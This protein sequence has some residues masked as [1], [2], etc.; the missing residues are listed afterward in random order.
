MSDVLVTTH[1]AEPAP[2]DPIL[3]RPGK[4]PAR[5][6]RY[7]QRILSYRDLVPVLKSAQMSRVLAVDLET[8]GLDYHVP[9]HVQIVG[10]GLAWDHGSCYIPFTELSAKNRQVLLDFLATFP[11]ELLAHNAYFDMGVLRTYRCAPSTY[12]CTRALMYMLSNEGY[13]GQSWGLKNA[14]VSL[15]GW[16]EKGDVEL[17]RWLVVN[18]Y[19]VGNRRIDTSPEYLMAEFEAK[20]LR[21]DKGQMWHAPIDILGKYCCLDAESTYLLFTEILQ[22]ALTQ[23][24]DLDEFY[25]RDLMFLI[26][27]HIE[28][29]L[30]GIPA[31]RP[32][33]I[34]R[35][36]YL[37]ILMGNLQKQFV[38]PDS[39]A[40]IHILGYQNDKYN[41]FLTTEPEKLKKNGER[42]KN[43][44]KW[45]VRRQ[46]IADS[47]NPDYLFNIC[48][49][50]QMSWLLYDK[51]GMEKRILT[52]AGEPATGIKALK[53]MPQEIVAPLIEHGYARKELGYIEDYISRT[54][55]SPTIHPDFRMPGTVTGRLS[56]SKPNLQQIPKSNAV[57]SLF[58]ARPGHV[59]IDLDFSAL[60]PV[61]ATEFSQDANMLR[62]YG[63]T[64]PKNDI[65]LFVAAHIP[66]ISEKVRA[67]GYDP[68]KPTPE[69]LANA[70][71]LCKHE[72]GICKTVVLACQYGAGVNKVQQTLEADNIFLAYEEVE[73]IHSGYWSLF[74][75]L[76]A[77]SKELYFQWKRNGGW[78]L[79]GTGRPMCVPADMTKD[80]LNR[81]VQSTGHDILVK[82]V[83][84]FI[85]EMR[86]RG[87]PY[88][89]VC[90][91][92][93]DSCCVEV[94]EEYR[95]Q[96]A[97]V[98]MDSL[99]ELNR[100]LGGI[101]KLRGEPD[102]GRNL[103]DVK[104]PEE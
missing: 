79:N 20:K 86:Y 74:S 100:Q 32:G 69:G 16:E 85:E 17:D 101:I 102:I 26:D 44:I 63:N 55:F 31:D 5:T 3:L 70:K 9:D 27:Q 30:V 83:R 72:R 64:A 53:L 24:P 39:P 29:K 13:F 10:I 96:T 77:F 103:A 50:Q 6:G 42:S 22:P 66:G 84:L 23:F 18:G 60:E 95:E 1:A 78:I 58:T 94:L 104:K 28:Q 14:Q 52:D 87:I 67:A 88:T 75:G 47:K 73:K 33:L 8:T 36:E 21:P 82:Y 91:D 25:S 90:L 93:H 12:L 49:G 81:F 46:D 97:E 48:S 38:G 2:Q 34:A 11:G 56:S 35:A 92:W 51:L 43:W 65:Y 99:D 61:V 15:L 41:E 98:F 45:N 37:N 71:K 68:Y 4:Y 59:W 7:F 62:I 80:L 19:Y 76:K 57:M 54:E 89:P 40:Y